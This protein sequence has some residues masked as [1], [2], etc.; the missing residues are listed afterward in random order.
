MSYLNNLAL[1]REYFCIK[2]EKCEVGFQGFLTFYATKWENVILYEK[3]FWGFFILNTRYLGLK[4]NVIATKAKSCKKEN[5]WGI[6]I[7]YTV[8]KIW[9]EI[10]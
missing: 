6:M 3:C 7:Q 4:P 9:V 8:L 2:D 5:P 1:S 10:C